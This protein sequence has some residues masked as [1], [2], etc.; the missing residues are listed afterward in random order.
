MSDVDL[1]IARLKAR[2]PDLGGRV[3][4]AAEFA[5][6]AATG[7]RPQVTPAAHVIPTGI[8]GKP[9]QPQVGLYVQKIERLFSVILSLRAADVSAS[10]SL[11][12]AADMIE[13]IIAAMAGWELGSRIGVMM[14]QRCNLVDASQ[15]A[16]AYELSFS[17]SDQ[18]RINPS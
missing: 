6:L 2:V 7:K 16:L 18:L 9:M 5:A 1:I 13:A 12:P 3:A 17:L 4:G 14:F 10:R 15:G 8:A 11:T